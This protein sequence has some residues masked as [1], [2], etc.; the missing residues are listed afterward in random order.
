MLSS[1]T[2]SNI[3]RTGEVIRM[4]DRERKNEIGLRKNENDFALMEKRLNDKSKWNDRADKNILLKQNSDKLTPSVDEWL[5]KS[6]AKK[7]LA[8]KN[9]SP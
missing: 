7:K 9:Q 8:R 3:T 2:L 6:A 1:Q 5:A 4:Y